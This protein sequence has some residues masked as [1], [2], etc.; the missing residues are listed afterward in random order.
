MSNR[1]GETERLSEQRGCKVEDGEVGGGSSI[2]E[3]GESKMEK[4]ERGEKSRV[5]RWAEKWVSNRV[6]GRGGD[7]RI[8]E[9]K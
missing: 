9:E 1:V 7:V 3:F 2:G 5:R 8:E 6:G 4:F